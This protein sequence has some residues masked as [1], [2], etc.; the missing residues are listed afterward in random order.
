MPQG[1]SPNEQDQSLPY[2]PIIPGN[3]FSGA[4]PVVD[5]ENNGDA[6]DLTTAP[7]SR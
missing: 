5:N 7:N 2:A 3:R 1:D 4:V 6:S